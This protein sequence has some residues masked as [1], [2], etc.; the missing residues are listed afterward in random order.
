MLPSYPTL[1]L[2]G[3]LAGSAAAIALAR[4]GREVVL[5]ERE[6]AAKHKVCGEF[7]SAEALHLLAALGI[8]PAAHGAQPVHTVRLAAYGPRARHTAETRLPFAAR[9]LTRRCLDELLL[10]AAEQAGASVLRGATVEALTTTATGWQATLSDGQSLSAPTVILATGKHDLR[11]LPR[12]GGVQGD[13]VALK[14]YW[15]LKE[16]QAAALA[17]SVELLLHPHGYTGLQSVETGAANLTALVR[18]HHLT[19]LG[20]WAGLLAELLETN[21]HAAERLE[22]AIPLLEKPLAISAI[23]YGFV[24]KQAVAPGLYAVGDQAAVIPSFTGDGMSIALCTG[25]MAAKALLENEP[26]SIFQ[27]RL[28][29]TVKSQIARAIAVS[30]LAVHPRGHHLL[31]VAA[32]LYPGI[33]ARTAALTRLPSSALNT[34]HTALQ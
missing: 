7:L 24:R 23:P 13:L 10:T 19:R 33:L 12:P 32:R 3:G 11:G 27:A 16:K 18:R 34:A 21:P 30:R 17:H 15:R 4:A 6:R 31:T 14:M 2:G 22:G 8:D 26:A 1:I 28:H 5:L 9:S 20:G 25:L 29:R